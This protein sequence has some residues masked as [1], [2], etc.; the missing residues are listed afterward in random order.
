MLRCYVG[1][2]PPDWYEYIKVKRNTYNNAIHSSTHFAPFGRLIRHQPTDQAITRDNEASSQ[3]AWTGKE[4]LVL[5]LY[6]TIAKARKQLT[7]AKER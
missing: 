1:D 5:R 3:M 7:E 2:H 4:R 6:A